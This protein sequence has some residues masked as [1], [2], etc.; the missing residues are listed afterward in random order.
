MR[1][2]NGSVRQEACTYC[3]CSSAGVA[4]GWNGA[5][6]AATRKAPTLPDSAPSYHRPT[7]IGSLLLFVHSAPERRVSDTIEQ[8][9]E[10]CNGQNG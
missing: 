6:L 4:T 8:S 10:N 9:R 3:L 7:E 2:K 1:C 5:G